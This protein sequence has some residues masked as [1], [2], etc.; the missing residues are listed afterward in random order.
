MILDLDSDTPML[1]LSDFHEMH[2]VSLGRNNNSLDLGLLLPF[3]K[4]VYTLP[5]GD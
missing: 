4:G 5:L 2:M 1:H 3:G